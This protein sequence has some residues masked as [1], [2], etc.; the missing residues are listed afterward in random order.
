MKGNCYESAS[1]CGICDA[2]HLAVG[3]GG[4]IDGAADL[5]VLHPLEV[6]ERYAE[7][8]SEFVDENIKGYLGYL[9]IPLSDSGLTESDRIDNQDNFY[10]GEG[11]FLG[12]K[13]DVSIWYEGDTPTHV[14]LKWSEKYV[15][16]DIAKMVSD[17]VGAELPE[18]NEYKMELAIPGTDLMISIMNYELFDESSIYIEPTGDPASSSGASS[19]ESEALSAYT[20]AEELPDG[21]FNQAAKEAIGMLGKPFESAG[22]DAASGVSTGSGTT[23]FYLEG[24]EFLGEPCE[25]GHGQPR[26]VHSD[27]A[28]SSGQGLPIELFFS[29]ANPLKS[30][31]HEETMDII[32][33]ISEALGLEETL[34]VDVDYDSSSKMATGVYRTVE[35]PNAKLSIEVR[36]T[37]GSVEITISR[38]G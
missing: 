38:M 36:N 25:D 8:P 18:V 21:L 28:I 22:L 26:L 29:Y 33:G 1:I 19:S 34:E 14:D 23:I 6:R 30:N 11:I 10:V 35:I 2:L 31:G 4:P 32:E 3:L 17:S 15:V 37:D 12:R 20:S 24:L 27:E 9:D 13:V 16:E 7:L 5:N